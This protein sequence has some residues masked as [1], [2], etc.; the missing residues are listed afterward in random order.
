[1]LGVRILRLVLYLGCLPAALMSCEHDDARTSDASAPED[2]S[3]PVE[4]T[5]FG[6][7]VSSY[8]ELSQGVVTRVGVRIPLSAIEAAP[9]DAPFQ[10]DLVLDMPQA[11]KQQTILSQLRV[12]WLAHG[13][14]P[15]PYAGPHFDFHFYRGSTSAI[16]AITCSAEPEFPPEILTADH[17]SPSSCVAGMGYHAWPSADALPD[18]TFTASLILGYVPNQLVFIE[19]MITQATLLEKHD[20]ELAITP[21]RKSGGAP[22]RYPTLVRARFEPDSESY[23]LELDAFVELD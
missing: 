20:F 5:L 16:D 3:A 1:M 10:N 7:K 14:G 8:V 11:A 13:H 21:P 6:F 12:N 2:S 18:A 15:V 19:P 22:T 23:R 9:D 4:G 17:E